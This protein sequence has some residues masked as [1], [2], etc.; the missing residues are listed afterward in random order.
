MEYYLL[1]D[2]RLKVI[3]KTSGLVLLKMATRTVLALPVLQNRLHIAAVLQLY[4]K[5][6]QMSEYWGEILVCK[7]HFS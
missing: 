4:L 1:S 3:L 2:V 5:Q 6:L 7:S